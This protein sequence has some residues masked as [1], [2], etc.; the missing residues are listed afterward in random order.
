MHCS[1]VDETATGSA[2]FWSRCF[3]IRGPA[4]HVTRLTCTG[5]GGKAPPVAPEKKELAEQ[6]SALEV[7]QQE[8]ADAVR[9]LATHAAVLGLA[10]GKPESV[11]SADLDAAIA[12]IN[13]LAARHSAPP[14]GHATA[15]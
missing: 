15:V 9:E 4:A 3:R 2:N 7:R 13:E 1:K 14:E 12:G 11:P 8:L 5:P 6:L 10:V